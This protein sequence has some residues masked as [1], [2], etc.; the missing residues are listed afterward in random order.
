MLEFDDKQ[1]ISQLDRLP[2]RLRA[3]FA[4]ACAERLVPNY[5]RY[6]ADTGKFDRSLLTTALATLWNNIQENEHDEDALRDQVAQCELL[7]SDQN[8]PE[9]ECDPY[10]EDAVVS[11][12]YAITTRLD[13]SSQDAMWA[14][15]RVLDS[16]EYLPLM[17]DDGSGPALDD[18]LMAEPLVQAE[19]LRQQADMRDLLSI[20]E[21]TTKQ[22]EIISQ[23]HER[24]KAASLILWG[25]DGRF[26]TGNDNLFDEQHKIGLEMIKRGA[27][28]TLRWRI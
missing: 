8:F 10:A 22:D 25:P 26:P 19:L 6:A 17:R 5:V 13:G 15:R 3:V 23:L 28:R 2:A 9:L 11:T 20:A 14:A 24:A 1:L 12:I 18:R 16:L 21:G 7:L 4:A 27:R